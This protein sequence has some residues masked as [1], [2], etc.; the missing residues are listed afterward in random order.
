MVEKRWC[1]PSKRK[2]CEEAG[3]NFVM[4]KLLKCC[5][6]LFFIMRESNVQ[7]A[8]G[9]AGEDRVH[10]VVSEEHGWLF[11]GIY[12]GLIKHHKDSKKLFPWRFGLEAK[13]KTEAMGAVLTYKQELGMNYNFIRPDL[14]MGSC[15]QTP[16]DVDKLRSI[17][18][19]TIVF[20]ACNKIQILNIL[21][22]ISLAFVNMPTHMMTFNTCVLK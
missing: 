10:V 2:A 5:A 13:E 4:T 1:G 12:D 19:K 11:V 15:L 8:L 3:I 20:F 17:G 9:K 22:L 21:G 14:I 16:D 7:W 6:F 18:V